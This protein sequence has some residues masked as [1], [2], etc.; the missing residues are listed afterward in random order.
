MEDKANPLNGAIIHDKNRLVEVLN[1]LRARHPFVFKLSGENGFCL[2]IGIGK[3]G[4]VQHSRCDGRPPY[5][6]AVA[7]HP[8]NPEE[9]TEFLCGGTPSPI[10]NRYCMPFDFV[11]EIAGYFLETG[12][13]HPGFAWEPV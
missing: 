12:R 7:P 6:L 10:S 5:V 1:G 2:D 8:E 9:D 3:I 13:A 4:C 11:C